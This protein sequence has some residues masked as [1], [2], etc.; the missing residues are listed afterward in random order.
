MLLKDN[1]DLTEH[2]ILAPIGPTTKISHKSSDHVPSSVPKTM[3]VI[4]KTY[5]SS[6][7]QYHN[8]D[9][10]RFIADNRIERY[11]NLQSR[12]I[13]DQDVE[14]IIYYALRN[15]QVILCIHCIENLRINMIM[16]VK[17]V[18]ISPAHFCNEIS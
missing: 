2:F 11:F 5:P 7:P 1:L 4:E 17:R 6:K 9:L 16:D 18:R 10:E 3:D 12:N 13:T 14:I 15:N 8:H